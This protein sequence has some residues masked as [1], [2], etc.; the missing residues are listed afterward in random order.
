MQAIIIT[1]NIGKDAEQRTTQGGDRI[2]SF[3][4][5]SKQGYGQKE[6]T[7]W[8]RCSLWGARGDKLGPY[9]LK[10]QAVTVS[11]ELEIGEY[12][13][14][15]Q[16]NIRVN[17]VAL[18]GSRDDGGNRSQGGGAAPPARGFNDAAWDGGGFNDDLN[19]DVPFMS[20]A[21]TA[22]LIGKRVI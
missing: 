13:G 18:Q 19:D 17:D 2:C 14:K 9:L 4:V 20:N 6:Q 11:G 15:T 8:F 22:D 1:G 12:E 5:A 16:L 10:G 3:S 21:W 7:N